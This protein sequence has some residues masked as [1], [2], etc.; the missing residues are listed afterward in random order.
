MW[1]DEEDDDIDGS[2]LKF[3]NDPRHRLKLSLPA[4]VHLPNKNEAKELRRLMSENNM[5]EKQIRA[6]PVFRK[7]LAMA[8]EKKGTKSELDRR[9]LIILKDITKEVKLPKSHPIVVER[10][11]TELNNIKEGKGNYAHSRYWK[12]KGLHLMMLSNNDIMRGLGLV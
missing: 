10:F 7:L 3:S 6:I 2:R 1:Y 4:D 11:K 12:Y 8:R 9:L 5:S